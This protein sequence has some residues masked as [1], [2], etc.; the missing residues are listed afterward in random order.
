MPLPPLREEL[1]LAPG[2]ALS[3]GQPSHTL[4]DPV[5][6]C[7]FQIDWPSFEVMSRWSLADPAA[8]AAAV[9]AE[10][11]LKMTT[12]EVEAIAGFFAENQ[13]LQA[14]PG[15]AAAFAARKK[16]RR[17]GLGRW[18]LHNYLYF[19]IPLFKPDRWLEYW[20]PR[21]GF[22]WSRRFLHV[23]LV[24]L[25]FGLVEVYR[26]WESFASTLVDMVSWSGMASYGLTIV[27]VKILHE[28]G[29]GLTAKRYGC[30][31]PTMGIAFL[32]LWPVA[33]TD[34]ND[35]WKLAD[36]RRRLHVAAAGILTELAIAIWATFAW[37]LLPEGSPRSIA[38]LLATTT[39]IS[40]LA[41]NAS[42]FLRFDGYFL[43]SDWL[44]IANLHSRA[45]ALARWDLRERLFKLGDPPPEHF[46]SRRRTG[47][48]FFAYLTW[49]YRL[50][51]FVGIALLVYTFFI[52]AIGILL[53]LVEIGW[54]IL[55]PVQRELAFW[56]TR[57]PTIRQGGR[58]WIA[59]GFVV[60]GVALLLSPWPS[61]ISASALLRPAEQLVLYAPP[62]AFV[63]ALPVAEGQR[64]EAGAVLLRLAS[65]DL[66]GRRA[67]AQARA[68]S[69]RW[70]ATA[71]ALDNEQRAHWQVLQDQLATAEAEQVSVEADAALYEPIA[72]FAG[73][74]ADI[75][76]ELRPDIWL[77]R[78]EPLARL[79]ADGRP[80]V[81]AYLDEED[82]ARVGV[83]NRATFYS[84]SP[85]GPILH[86]QVSGIDADASRNLPEAELSSHYG[87]N[88]AVREKNGQL[89]PERPIFRVSLTTS[90]DNEHGPVRTWRG[91][92]VIAGEWS[93]PGWRYLRAALAAVRREAGF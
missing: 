82:V 87:G 16:N 18:L 78:G 42:P 21:L 89:H 64:V 73:V 14:A 53:F 83:G 86:L 35:V 84:D 37:T 17:G 15:C 48:V 72:P 43:L 9:T 69:L 6:N 79:V 92:V 65:P 24:A 51:V 45:F 33:Y 40:T 34:T 41:I 59:I 90:G 2:P 13:L 32:V 71:G 23:S 39:W 66:A 88:I 81:V 85:D 19:R 25:L 67:A 46:P 28:L 4:H 63:V 47:L 56:R 1:T 93:A 58:A 75:D 54:F 52:K 12:D 5:R 30:R 74:L 22:L 27:A 91:K 38:F 29:H 62:R 49:T 57:W 50:V 3:D 26:Q 31:V 68:E 36:R 77:A 76:P 10:T 60:A 11:T 7:Y 61:R 80:N 55:L 20:A 8:I 44:G 70:Q